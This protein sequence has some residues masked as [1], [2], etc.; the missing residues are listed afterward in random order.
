[1]WVRLFEIMPEIGNLRFQ[2]AVL[3][4]D[5]VN[6]DINPID[7]ADEGEEEL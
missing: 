7:A 5:A 3:L 1:M 4:E 2:I 6:L